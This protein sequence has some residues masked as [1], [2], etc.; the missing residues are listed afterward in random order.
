MASP[1]AG[2]AS[3]PEARGADI[4]A[5]TGELL[6]LAGPV[7]LS[8]LGIMAMGLSDAV[9]VGRYSAKELGYHALGWA[10]TSVALTVS[11]GLLVGVQVMTARAV[12]EGRRHEVGAVLRRGLAY[13]FWVGLA[14]A[15]LLI[16]G[17]P[18]LMHG[19]GLERDLADG[20]SRVLMIFALSL[21]FT[22]ISVAA[23]SWLEAL[24]KPGVVTVF[25][26][27]ANI[28]NLGLLLLM[29]PGTFGLP[30]L[31]AVGGGWATFGA[32][33]ALAVMMVAYI[34]RMAEA[35]ALGVFDKPPRDRAAEAEQRRIGYGAGASNFFEVAAFA[36]MNV[37]AGWIGV[38]AVA[39]WAVVLNVAA[40]I[41]MVPLGISTATTVLV[42]RAY[43][44]RDLPGVRRAGAI[45][46]AVAAV[47]GVAVSLVVW[48]TASLIASGYTTDPAAIALAVPALVLSCLFFAPDALQ[49]V[50]AQA[51][52]AR[53]DVWVPTI[54]HMISY[55]AIMTP[56]AWWFA[57]P[58]G[59]G[60]VGVV[61]A[62]IIASFAAMGFL[63]ARWLM[64]ARRL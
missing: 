34:W 33:A 24:S 30:A 7:V 35:R 11:L 14:A 5:E 8:R 54:T 27:V 44:A 4:R 40:V 23:S 2:V 3:P 52:R 62:V 58:L 21:P 39:S 48:P 59:H 1:D 16:A 63:G 22:T 25:M 56:L 47:F 46:F 51:L 15:G 43:G 45:G 31:G 32:R 61:W 20:S 28:I 6:R 50:I 26:W 64:L 12:G 29:V 57:I 37:I 55:A 38:L 60:L 18:A 13:S 53:G 36:S 9:V 42:G 41:F 19:L 10:P 17:G 49:V